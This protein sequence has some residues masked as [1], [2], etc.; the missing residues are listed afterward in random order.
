MVHDP[1][2]R[3]FHKLA[4]ATLAAVA[5]PARAATPWLPILPP[6]PASDA[7]KIEVLEFFSW[8]CPHCRD[9]NPSLSRWAAKLPKDVSFHRVPI[10]FG[11]ASWANLARLFYALDALDALD[12][13]DDV[14]FAA[15][16]ERRIN[17]YTPEA[18]R[19][20]AQQQGLDPNR[21][22]EAFS[23]FSTETHIARAEQLSRAYKVNS[24]PALSVAGRY[25]ITAETA[26]G[27]AG[28]LAVADELIAKSRKA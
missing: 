10:S 17:L 25:M 4:L 3:H 21:F 28:M 16:H 27:H 20:W 26:Q 15:I 22:S 11:R 1:S 5:L 13:L 2:R 7:G 18:A 6:Q 19:N 9:F 23:G 14:A 24:V 12:R 8:G